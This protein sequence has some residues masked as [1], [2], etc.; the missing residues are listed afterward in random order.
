MN[1]LDLL[2]HIFRFQYEDIPASFMEAVRMNGISFLHGLLNDFS[3]LLEG[4]YDIDTEFG[5]GFKGGIVIF[6]TDV[7]AIFGRNPPL[8]DKIKAMYLSIKA[9]LQKDKRLNKV[10][11]SHEEVYGVSVGK[12]FKG[13]YVSDKGTFD[14]NSTSIEIIGISFDLLCTIAAEIA[15]EF[16]QETV[17]VKDNEAHRIVLVKPKV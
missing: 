16:R 13:R 17:L 7:N 1:T 12:Y 15:R 9:R 6:S 14:E 4:E 3:P 8:K 11:F 5:E 2:S 10:M